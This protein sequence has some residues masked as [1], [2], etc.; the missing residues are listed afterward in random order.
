MGTHEEYELVALINKPKGLK[1]EV[2]VVAPDGL[3]LSLFEGLSVWIVPPMLEGVR[4]TWIE[5]LRDQKD[6][7]LVKLA[8]VDSL[9]TARD[10]VGRFLLVRAD[11]VRD[12]APVGSDGEADDTMPESYLGSV[13]Y[14]EAKGYIGIVARVE[15]T[16]AHP[17]LVVTRDAEPD[18][19]C[20][21]GCDVTREVEYDKTCDAVCDGAP[22]AELCHFVQPEVLIPCVAEFIIAHQEGRLDVRLPSG[23]LELNQKKRK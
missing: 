17:L 22:D 13:V 7:S 20:G 3:P 19:P 9:D 16:P 14:D 6:G 18:V 8:G 23:L 1:G 11:D 2:I 4:T 10:L 12:Y 21:A 5:R 15:D